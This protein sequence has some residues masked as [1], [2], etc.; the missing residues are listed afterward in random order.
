MCKLVVLKFADGSFEQGFS[1][2]LQIGDEGERP[3]TEIT[4]RL[5]AAIDMPIY[6]DR[7]QASYRHLGSRY[8]LSA[9]KVQVT[10]VSVT[11]DCQETAQSLRSRF[12]DWLR[13][14]EFRPV[15]EKWLEK[16]L[17]TDELRVILQ[18]EDYQLKRLPWHLWDVIERY[19]KAEVAIASPTYERVISKKTRN[20]KVNILAILGNSEGIDTD[21]DLNLLQQLNDA[22]V[23][24]LVEPQ[25]K[26]LNDQLWGNSWDIL[27][28]AGHSSSYGKDG[29]G[30]IYLNTTD[31]L[32]IGEL[33]YALRKAV[34]SGLQLAIFNSCDGLGLARDLADLQ[35]PQMIVMREPVPDLVAQEFLKNFLKSFASGDLLYLAVREARERLQGLEDKF[36]CATWL[37]VICQ[38]LAEAPPSW[39]QITGRVELLPLKPLPSSPSSSPKITVAFFSSVVVTA[40]V[41]G[42]RFLGLLQGSELQAFDQMVA[43][44][45]AIVNEKPD[46]RLLIVT[47]DDADIAEQRRNGERLD[48]KSLSDRSLNKLLEKLEQYQPRVIGLDLYRDFKAQ[49][50][51][52]VTRLQQTEN[53]VGVCKGSD[54]VSSING[55]EPPPEIPEE[56]LGFSDFVHDPDG[57]VRRHLLVMDPEAISLCPAS[58]A[59]STQLAFRYLLASGIQPKFTPNGD[60][61]LG[62]TVFLGL[63]PRTGGYQNID[64][65]G[66]QI[67]L[68]YRSSKNIAEQVTLRQILSTPINPN[69]VKDKIVLIGVAARGDYPDYWA[70]PYGSQLDEQIPGVFVQAHMVS[71][72]ISAVLDGRQQLQVLSPLVEVGWILGWCVVSGVFAWRVRSF[73]K[74]ALFIGVVSGS[75]YI[76]CFGMLIQGYWVP[77]VPS[78]L[79]LVVTV[80]VTSVQ[81]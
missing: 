72:I 39:K 52:L 68:N 5:P 51:N 25:R 73:P 29:N 48:G 60:L 38:N 77:F 7:W 4:G 36:P 30:L 22:N 2:T 67:L 46:D 50:P 59:F 55:I 16:L 33:R 34:E 76:F 54:G 31:S 24:F 78:A 79:A 66:G 45:P 35:I 37:P 49:N 74:L 69:A 70:T 81:R 19:P 42:L 3:S 80:V 41:C 6:Y 62:K 20:D 21:A 75:L 12:N 26:E 32:T 28:F 65:N 18:T 61:Q 9:D 14:E 63:K 43:L 40:L 10:N 13:S 44:R 71:Q 53:L 1:V 23:T 27:F 58:F 11:E 8:R 57:V 47:I 56:R 15:R 17:A 64:T